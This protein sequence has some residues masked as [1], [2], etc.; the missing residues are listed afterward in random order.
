MKTTP[1]LHDE[2]D[3]DR[4]Q[5]A[6][7]KR[8]VAMSAFLE[9]RDG[10]H[11]MSPFECDTCIFWKLTGKE[12]NPENTMKDRMLLAC[13]RRVNLDAFWSRMSSTVTT[14]KDKVR[15]AIKLSES[16][17]LNGPF[18]S[19][20]AFPTWDHCGYEVAIQMVL[21][22]LKPGRYSSAYTQ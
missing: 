12:P 4:L 1:G 21:A 2:I 15:S 20:S 14:N 3:G 18:K 8:Q 13:I 9:A 11:L 22:S 10:D 5:Q 7:G 19:T 17:G 16:V 6:W